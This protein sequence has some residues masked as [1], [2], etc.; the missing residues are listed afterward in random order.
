MQQ[1]RPFSRFDGTEEVEPRESLLGG[2]QPVVTTDPLP[3]LSINT[4]GHMPILLLTG[5]HP[6]PVTDQLAAMV[7]KPT[8][9]MSHPSLLSALQST[10]ETSSTSRLLVIPA[11]KKQKKAAHAVPTRHMKRSVRHILVLLATLGVLVVTLITLAPLSGDQNGGNLLDSFGNMLRS[12]QM[13]SQIQ[14]HMNAA[15]AFDAN[16]SGLPFLHIPNSPYVSVAQQAATSAGI[17]PVYFVRQIDQE[18]GFNPNAVSVTDA[19]GIAQFEPATAAGLGI[20]PWDP[21][22]ALYG[23]AKMMDRY[24]VKYGNYAKALGAYNAGPGS[25][26]NAVNNCGVNWL[27]CMPEQSQNYVYVIMGI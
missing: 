22:Q 16:P 24:Y 18:S 5:T 23:A 7:Q 17:S 9:T 27:S 4:T 25:L 11:G 21:I 12:A 19:E 8:P 1:F 26:Q 3:A 10:M 15:Q 20:N 14:A 6:T 2:T 13:D